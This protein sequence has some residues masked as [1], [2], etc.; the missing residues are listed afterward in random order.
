M[1]TLNNVK[2]DYDLEIQRL[3]EN[4]ETTRGPNSNT[5]YK[6]ARRNENKEKN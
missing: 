5:K 2:T 3:L 4:R 6:T 1:G